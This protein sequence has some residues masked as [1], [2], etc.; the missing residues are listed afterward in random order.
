MPLGLGFFWERL[1]GLT[2]ST[3]KKIL[4]LTHATLESLQTIVV[5]VEAVLNNHPLT[6]VSPDVKDMDPVTPS[7]LLYGRSIIS[8]PYQDVQDDEVNDP[9][10]GDDADLRK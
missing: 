6:N 1:I 5:E 7:H 3:L 8:L 9:T 4:G 2:K 10:Y